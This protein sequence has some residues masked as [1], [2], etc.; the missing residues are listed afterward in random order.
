MLGSKKFDRPGPP[1]KDNEKSEDFSAAPCKPNKTSIIAR[2]MRSLKKF[3]TF[4]SKKSTLVDASVGPKLESTPLV[5]DAS[6]PDNLKVI[7]S[8]KPSL[9][10]PAPNTSRS[11]WIKQSIKKWG[12]HSTSKRFNDACA[13]G[14]WGSPSLLRQDMGFHKAYGQDNRIVFGWVRP[15]S[16]Q[17]LFVILGGVSLAAAIVFTAVWLPLQIVAFLTCGMLA[18]PIVLV[19]VVIDLLIIIPAEL[20]VELF[21]FILY[22]LVDVL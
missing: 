14:P 16:H 7:L 3:G 9:G 1:V 12:Y 11:K 5:V 19:L 21:K 4:L 17:A 22:I 6:G 18:P 20:A 15:S 13:I 2:S 8:K 10:N